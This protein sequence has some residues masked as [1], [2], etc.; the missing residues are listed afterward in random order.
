MKTQ[1]ITQD[2]LKELLDYRDGNLWWRVKY[3]SNSLDR[4]A[5]CFDVNDGYWAIK[6]K[7]VKY[8]AHR[9]IWIYVYGSIDKDL[10]IDH[11]DG[12]KLNN[13]IENLRLVTNRENLH[14]SHRHRAGKLAGTSYHK[15][16]KKWSAQIYVNSKLFHI[17]D[18]R[19]EI[20]AH[21]AYLQV[22]KEWVGY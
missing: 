6:V 5:G 2:T 1:E 13:K 17:G 18:Y 7:Q 14:N 20:E 19:T 10:V 9:L 15:R 3:T 22:R 11:I 12:N 8:L 16:A 4:P 21:M